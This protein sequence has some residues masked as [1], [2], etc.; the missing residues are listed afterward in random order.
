MFYKLASE[1]TYEK[2][3]SG[4]KEREREREREKERERERESRLSS[5][6]IVIYYVFKI[7]PFSVKLGKSNFL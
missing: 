5:V 1:T 6:C 3:G 2:M 4:R 7:H